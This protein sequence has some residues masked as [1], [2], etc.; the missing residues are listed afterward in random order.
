MRAV[1]VVV[2]ILIGVALT[3]CASDADK[4]ANLNRQLVMYELLLSDCENGLGDYAK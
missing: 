2:G 1:Y 4:I 3:V